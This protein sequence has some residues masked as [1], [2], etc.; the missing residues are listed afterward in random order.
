MILS[1][2][3]LLIITTETAADKKNGRRK[4]TNLD[5]RSRAAN[6]T[7]SPRRL[8]VAILPGRHHSLFEQDGQ[9]RFLVPGLGGE[10]FAA[11]PVEAGAGL[12]EQLLFR[13]RNQPRQLA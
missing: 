13:L 5:R 1:A 6:A 3:H 7:V 10:D 8:A 11:V 4:T 2:L 12:Q 9:S